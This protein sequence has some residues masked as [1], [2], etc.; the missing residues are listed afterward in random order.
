M[1][2]PVVHAAGVVKVDV[3]SFVALLVGPGA[4]AASVSP[5]LS[6]VSKP[7]EDTLGFEYVRCLGGGDGVD[8]PSST[9]SASMWFA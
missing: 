5:R 1:Q 7:G 8:L 6:R 2:G 3:E 9:G 4:N